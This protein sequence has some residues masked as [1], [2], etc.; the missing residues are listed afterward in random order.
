MEDE[1][2]RVIPVIDGYFL[3]FLNSWTE[4]LLSYVRAFRAFWGL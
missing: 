1:V 2:E 3:L 4:L